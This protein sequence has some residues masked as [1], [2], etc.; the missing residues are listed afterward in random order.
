MIDTAEKLEY[1]HNAK[2]QIGNQIACLETIVGVNESLPITMPL[3][4]A[5]Q[6]TDATI[7]LLE[8]EQPA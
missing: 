2:R 1:L 4:Q 3:L 8:C 7:R 6:A 5:M